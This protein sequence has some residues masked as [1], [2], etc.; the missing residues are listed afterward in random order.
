MYLQFVGVYTGRHIFGGATRP[1][2]AL[3][4]AIA[5]A[6]FVGAW[7][8]GLIVR[9][10]IAS[11]WGFTHEPGPLYRFV[12]APWLLALFLLGLYHL[13]AF[14]VRAPTRGDRTRDPPDHRD[15]GAVRRRRDHST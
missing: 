13:V 9:R 4:Y 12:F 6:L 1:V 5:A 15:R 2:F 7:L 8:D 14:T 3:L 11:D 10:M